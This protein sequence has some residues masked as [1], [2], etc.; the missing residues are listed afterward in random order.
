MEINFQNE[1]EFIRG[2]N[3]NEKNTHGSWLC[4]SCNLDKITK[5]EAIQNLKNKYLYLLTQVPI[6]RLI[7]KKEKEKL[8]WYYAEN[9]NLLFDNLISIVEPPN[10]DPPKNL[11][12][13]PFPLWMQ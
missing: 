7:I 8:N 4:A 6:L 13:E 10:N 9:K 11:P 12:T 1:N 5:E 2:V 3:Y